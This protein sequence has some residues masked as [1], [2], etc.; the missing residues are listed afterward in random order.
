MLPLYAKR[1]EGRIINIHA[2]S[3]PIGDVD[4]PIAEM[5]QSRMFQNAIHGLP[6]LFRGQRRVN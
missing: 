5:K 3:W 4:V 6:L 2:Q 1:F